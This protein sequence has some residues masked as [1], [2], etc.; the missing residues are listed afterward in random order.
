MPRD[1][2]RTRLILGTAA[3]ADDDE[4]GGL[5]QRDAYHQDEDALIDVLLRH[6]RG[7]AAHEKR[8]LRLVALQRALAK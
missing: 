8:C 4:F 5:E 7:I 2:A 3:D 6:G 1:E